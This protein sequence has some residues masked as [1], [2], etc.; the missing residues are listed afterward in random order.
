MAVVFVVGS[1]AAGP[2]D[3]QFH[4]CIE[5]IED[6]RDGIDLYVVV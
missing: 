2:T 1:H 4:S 6:D 3:T 5:G